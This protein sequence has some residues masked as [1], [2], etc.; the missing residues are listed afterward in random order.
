[1]TANVGKVEN[2]SLA[3]QL[4]REMLSSDSYGVVRIG[5]RLIVNDDSGQQ[6]ATIQFNDVP[7]QPRCVIRRPGHLVAQ[8]HYSPDDGWVIFPI[9]RGQISKE[10]LRHADPL[11]FL[12]GIE[13]TQSQAA[14]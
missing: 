5:Y 8:C 9:Q 13:K 4:P 7:D 11:L 3:E 2:R 10:P 6:V 1:M 14:A 12:K